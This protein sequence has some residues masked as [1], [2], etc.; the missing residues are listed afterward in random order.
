[1]ALT[2]SRQLLETLLR[3]ASVPEKK[4]Y[5]GL[6]DNLDE[7]GKSDLLEQMQQNGLRDYDVT[8]EDGCLFFCFPVNI[9]YMVKK[10]RFFDSDALTIFHPIRLSGYNNLERGRLRAIYDYVENEL[11]VKDYSIMRDAGKIDL[12]L[13]DSEKIPEIFGKK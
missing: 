12:V 9:G 10:S 6:Y 3:G 11:G 1:M 5:T 13:G 4:H 7:A 8:V 2:P